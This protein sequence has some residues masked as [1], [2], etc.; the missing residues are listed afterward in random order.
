MR[1]MGGVRIGFAIG[2]LLLVS[3]SAHGATARVVGS[4]ILSPT[5]VASLGSVAYFS[6]SLASVEPNLSYLTASSVSVYRTD[7]TAGGT[8]VVASPAFIVA[9]EPAGGAVYFTGLDVQAL[10]LYLYKGT[11]SYPYTSTVAEI[12][13]IGSAIGAGSKIFMLLVNISVSPTTHE[14][15]VSDGTQ[16]GTHAVMA[17]FSEFGS[18]DNIVAMNGNVYFTATGGSAAAFGLWKSDGTAAGTVFLHEFEHGGTAAEPQRFQVFN[19]RLLF[20]ASVDGDI[21]RW[22]SDGTS[23]GTVPLKMELAEGWLPTGLYGMSVSESTIVAPRFGVPYKG[24]F[25]FSSSGPDS[26][27]LWKT[28]GTTAGTSL[29]K[30]FGTAHDILMGCYASGDDLFILQQRLTDGYSVSLYRSDGTGA[31][32]RLVKTIDSTFGASLFGLDGWVVMSTVYIGA[33]KSSLVYNLWLSDGTEPGTTIAGTFSSL[34]T[35]IYSRVGRTALFSAHSSEGGRLW[36][37]D[38]PPAVLHPRARFTATSRVGKPP[39]AVR[40]TDVSTPGADP[41]LTWHWDFGDGTESNERNPE[42]VYT[43]EDVYTV[44][45]TITTASEND[46]KTISCAVV[47]SDALPA[48][49]GA[50]LLVIMAALGVTAVSVIRKR[51]AAPNHP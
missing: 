34:Y 47:V 51:Y 4:S 2:W 25:Y 10:T 13:G 24:S 43:Q 16:A 21:W 18:S 27:G 12:P 5:H 26:A 29:V 35:E 45:L 1:S 6:P 39:L 32:T 41:I 40:F 48:P 11:A 31:H 15:W 44:T 49:R 9:Q 46:A 3:L 30:D 22:S 20:S 8:A 19:N 42:H 38:F 28:D 17:G 7:G 36:A 37:L 23:E 14:L 33:G 50:A